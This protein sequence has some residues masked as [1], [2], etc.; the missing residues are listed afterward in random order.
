MKSRIL[1]GVTF[2]VFLC[3]IL[4]SKFTAL[5]SFS[6]FLEPVYAQDSGE[7]FW[8]FDGHM[9]PT[10]STYHRGGTI[11]EANADP[12]FTLPLAEQGGLGAAFVNTGI[13]EFYEANHLAVKDALRQFDH[14]YRELA[15]Y[16]DRIGVATN[17]DQIR[18]LRG[19]GKIAAIL[20]IEGALAIESDLGVLR[21]Y[22][23]L[24]LREMNLVHLL[25]NNIG[26]VGF[27]QENNGKG[28]GLTDYGRQVVAEMNRLGILIDLS[29]TG[30]QTVLDV[31]AVST[32][33][34]S[35]THSGVRALGGGWSDEMIQTLARMNGVICVSARAQ[36]AAPRTD[37]RRRPP[38]GSRLMGMEPLLYTGDPTKIYEFIDERSRAGEVRRAATIEE[39][40][41]NMGPLSIL[42]DKIDYIVRLVG[43]DHVGFSTDFGG[44]PTNIQEMENA[45]EY[46]NIAQALLQRGYSRKDVA[47]IMGE[48][49]LRVFDEVVRTAKPQ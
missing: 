32:Q 12:R 19:E 30:E 24:G 7:P 22:H 25:G 4:S 31:M 42:I 20:S 1:M 33:P 21:M 6:A 34:V 23:R 18:A 14:F 39:R 8:V 36:V 26:D 2:T 48:N 41:R 37:T 28:Y 17:G 46:Q 43:V 47:K 3:F 9:H 45:G 35:T 27:S 49:V 13:D 10:S 5:P 15:K 16:P 38:R 29:H 11:G 44:F 40:L